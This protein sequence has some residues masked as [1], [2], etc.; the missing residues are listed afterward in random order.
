[1][2]RGLSGG[3]M[4]ILITG[5]SGFAGGH[6]AEALIGQP[7]IELIGLCRSGWPLELMHLSGQVVLETCDLCDGAALTAALTH[8]RPQQIY[9]LAGYANAG[10]SLHHVDAAWAGNLAATR[11]LYDAAAR[12]EARPRIL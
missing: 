4:R 7:S 11:N 12:L 8:I 3:L 6:L 5:I 9:H 10:R 2:A 1:E